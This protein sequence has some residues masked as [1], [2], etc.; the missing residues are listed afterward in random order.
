MNQSAEITVKG[1]T[2]NVQFAIKGHTYAATETDEAES[3]YI[4]LHSVWVGEQE[5]GDVLKESVIE[6][7]EEELQGYL[8]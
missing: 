8:R 7:I 6:A 2:F 5:L 3:P 4:E 1:C